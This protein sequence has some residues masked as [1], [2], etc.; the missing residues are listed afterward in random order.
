MRIA[1]VRHHA[2]TI[3]LAK[4][5]KHATLVDADTPSLTFAIFEGGGADLFASLN[6]VLRHYVGRLP[7][8]RLFVGRY[9]FNPHR[10]GGR[11]RLPRAPRPSEHLRRGR[12]GL[13]PGAARHR[14][15]LL[16]RHPRGAAE[17]IGEAGRR[18]LAWAKTA[19]SSH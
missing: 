6:E 15:G 11:E 13:R 8:S 12:Q 19:V 7:G 2:S 14:P 3:A 5:I 4:I 18:E 10:H 16:A 17:L 1:A 9:G